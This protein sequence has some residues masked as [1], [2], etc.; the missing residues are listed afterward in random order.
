M[1]KGNFFPRT[2]TRWSSGSLPTGGP[3][4]PTWVRPAS[5]LVAS[6][7]RVEDGIV[8]I[9]PITRDECTPARWE[10][11]QVTGVVAWNGTWN[12]GFNMG[13]W[14]LRQR[15]NADWRSESI[16]QVGQVRLGVSQQ[17]AI[18]SVPATMHGFWS[19]LGPF[20][21]LETTVIEHHPSWFGFSPSFHPM[22]Y[23]EIRDV[24]ENPQDTSPLHWL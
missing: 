23:G 17:Y 18:G 1:H 8:V 3:N 21:Q 22:T 13:T 12:D 6:Y 2:R 16:S 15:P 14:S 9:Q 19:A 7:F 10:Y 20:V 4:A 11:D 24:G 5:P